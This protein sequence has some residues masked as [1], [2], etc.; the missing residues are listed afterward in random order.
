MRR[1]VAAGVSG[2]VLLTLPG[3]PAVG[4]PPAASIV[5][6]ACHVS[7]IVDNLDVSA[8]F[9]H[10]VLG[11]DLV[12]A[13]PPGPL[14]VDTDPGHLLLHGVPRARLRFIGARMPGVRCGVEIVELTNVERKPVHRRYQDPGSA[15]L[16]LT[17]R[18][19]DAV[20]A[21]AKKDGVRV[22]T[23]GGVP[24]Q[25]A[26]TGAAPARALTVQDP[27][28]HYVELVQPDLIPETSV[29]VSSNVIAIGLRLT[30]ADVEAA[31]AF[32]R[33]VL[34]IEGQVRP[35]ERNRALLTLAGLSQS[36]ESRTATTPIPGSSRTLEFIQFRGLD[37]RKSA[38]S[39]RVQDP[40][41]YRLQLTFR[42]IDAT[43][44]ELKASGNHPVST[45]GQPVRMTF[46]GRP[47]RLA[48][49]PDPS[50]LFLIV[51]QGPS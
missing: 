5:V 42:D 7:P 11:F 41:S 25:I 28:D 38:E 15:T 1:V 46:G 51:Q 36:A 16:V 50:N 29:P 21:A 34:G 4:A 30:V 20:V 24:V 17:V 45:G 8:H 27:D 22:V 43:L 26:T 40:G 12:P 9:Y 19:L 39:S 10:D 23:T 48:I 37:A 6:N 33:H 2:L 44:A 18:N 14:P 3:G 13:P 35:F 47:W 49:V 31:V 32:Y